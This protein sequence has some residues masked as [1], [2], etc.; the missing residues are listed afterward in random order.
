MV[1]SETRSGWRRRRGV[2]A[3][4]AFAAATA[5]A[6]VFVGST[7]AAVGGPVCNVPT[8]YPTI[9]AAVNDP[10]CSTINVA[11]GTYNE[12]VLI[13]RTL[14]LNGAQAGNAVGG[15]ISGGPGES[16]VNG[17][18]LVAAIPVI[19]IRAADVTVDGF[20][21]KDNVTLSAAIG[22]Q[23]SQPG[24]NALITN[25]F[26]DSVTTPDTG[27]QGAAQAVYLVNG[28]DNVTISDNDL[29]NVTSPRSAKGVHIGD[30]A[31]TNPSVNT[32]I[33]RNVISNV[34]STAR[35]AYGVSLNNGNGT[36]ANS[37]LQVR[38]NA[39]TSLN[40]AGWVHAIGL[41]ANT[42]GAVVNG[43][44]VNGLTSPSTDAVAVWFEAD[45]SFSS[46]QVNQNNLAVT[47]AAYGIAVHPA[48]SGPALN[49]TCNWWGSA[50]GPTAASNPGGT[51]SKVTPGVN[52]QPWLL[53]PAPGGSCI[54]GNVPTDKNQC[55][56]NGWMTMV[57]AD[58]TVFK[59]QGDC[60]QYANTGK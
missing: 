25:N 16:T 57:R 56:G 43:N 12:N 59:N 52:Y 31:S 27:P 2:A 23:V 33:L 38:D 58:G 5:T 14:T 9:Q 34:T 22:I 11:P 24:N 13:N 18:N 42:P 15:R 19:N 17:V 37:G 32:S 30:A 49:G 60:I 45:P 48:L 35:G 20:T 1:D 3:V 53:G 41:E 46:A 7:Q 47:P 54:G 26:V 55:K 4:L 21:V 36:T 28:P 8:D 6:I 10:G 50:T 44:S 39:I 51:G 40:G 29:R